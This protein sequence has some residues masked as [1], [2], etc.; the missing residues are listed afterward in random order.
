MSC[1]ALTVQR[2]RERGRRVVARNP[3]RLFSG[4]EE[5]AVAHAR[6][7][8]E[9]VE[10]I[11]STHAS[12]AIIEGDYIL[13]IQVCVCRSNT[14]VPPQSLKAIVF[15]ASPKLLCQDNEFALFLHTNSWA[16]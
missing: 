7:V 10:D 5:A 1:P 15:V 12:D 14:P 6:T 13:Q 3:R 8:M 9:L 11:A 2:D 16:Q 4:T